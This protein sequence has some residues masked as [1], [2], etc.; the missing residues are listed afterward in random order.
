M[1]PSSLV[2]S[3]RD[4]D[5]ELKSLIDFLGLPVDEGCASNQ[6]V[7]VAGDKVIR[8]AEPQAPQACHRTCT[9]E[10]E[11]SAAKDG[12]APRTSQRNEESTAIRRN[13]DVRSIEASRKKKKKLKLESA[14]SKKSAA[15]VKNLES[16]SDPTNHTPPKIGLTGNSVPAEIDE[17]D[18]EIV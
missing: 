8:G 10:L 11:S 12:G 14:S 6:T 16:T 7:E 4:T 5:T 3:T 2:Q 18:W 15:S 9:A 1:F 13:I 17:D